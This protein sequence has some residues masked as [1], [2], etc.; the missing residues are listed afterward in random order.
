MDFRRVRYHSPETVFVVV[1]NT[2]A[3]TASVGRAMVWD[4]Q[5]TASDYDGYA[6]KLP[7]N[8]TAATVGHGLL[9]GVVA[10][11]DISPNEFGFVQAWGLCPSVYITGCSTAPFNGTVF[12]TA[13]TQAQFWTLNLVPVNCYVTD[14]N[15]EGY[16]GLITNSLAVGLQD[17]AASYWPGGR[18]YPVSQV[19][20]T[21]STDGSWVTGTMT[22]TSSGFIKAFIRCL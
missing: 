22:Y 21:V 13:L 20:T 19:Y 18:V 10:D 12:R 6:A 9:A 17:M 8:G 7:P 14:T 5:L 4:L 2:G 3:G 11:R 16:F 15:A 1:R